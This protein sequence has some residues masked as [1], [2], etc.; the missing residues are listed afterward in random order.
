MKITPMPQQVVVTNCD[1]FPTNHIII[2][3]T[4]TSK[5]L[6]EFKKNKN[7]MGLLRLHFH[8][9]DTI[10]EGYLHFTKDHAK[11]IV[12]FVNRHK[13][14]IEEIIIHCTAGFSR[15][16]GIAAALAKG[17]FNQDDDKYFYNFSPNRL[18]YRTLLEYI[19]NSYPQPTSK[20]CDCCGKK[21]PTGG[22]ST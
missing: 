18:V 22:Y 5:Y 16:P 15:S 20:T 17:L 14:R 1:W 10:K 8:D 11:Q 12:E 3:I 19:T 21:T 6:P 4:E 9:V 7:R 13:E 2:S